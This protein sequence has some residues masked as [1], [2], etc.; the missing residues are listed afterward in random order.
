MITQKTNKF[1][2]ILGLAI[3]AHTSASAQ[4]FNP[5]AILDGSFVTQN[6]TI[7]SQMFTTMLQK[8]L[9]TVE[10]LNTEDVVSKDEPF[11]VRFTLD[12][13]STI[14]FKLPS[15]TQLPRF[16]KVAKRLIALSP[17][18]TSAVNLNSL[19][20][21]S[22]IKEIVGEETIQDMV[23]LFETK[24]QTQNNDSNS[25]ESQTEAPAEVL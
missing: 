5:E 20:L 8:T 23:E 10:P 13:N 19:K 18:L 1:V 4:S 15:A 22:D 24:N 12:D 25:Q 17:A 14:V 6:I 3:A 9:E 2:F 16:I 7:A 11:K 21:L